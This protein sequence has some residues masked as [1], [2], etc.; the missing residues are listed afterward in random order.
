MTALA[1]GDTEQEVPSTE[2]SDEIGEM[3]QALLVFKQS[4][5]EVERMKAKE[6]ERKAAQDAEL[7]TELL[8]IADA[9]DQEVKAAVSIPTFRLET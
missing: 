7:K 5:G 6:D 2:R 1:N 8:Q 3:A 9:L 4:L